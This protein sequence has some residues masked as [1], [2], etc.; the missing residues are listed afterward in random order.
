MP[1]KAKLLNVREHLMFVQEAIELYKKWGDCDLVR[2][3]FGLA[4]VVNKAILRQHEEARSTGNRKDIYI[5][6]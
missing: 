4:S 6:Q 3:A 2:D 1:R 5:G